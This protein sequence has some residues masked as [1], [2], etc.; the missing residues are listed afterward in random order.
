VNEASPGA[1]WWRGEAVG[2]ALAGW[3]QRT[4]KSGTGC[5]AG[6]TANVIFRARSDHVPCV[7]AGI[8]VAQS[9]PLWAWLG[10]AAGTAGVRW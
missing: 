9:G 2:M 7:V 5:A 3:K 6:G 10:A 8:A 4:G 1:K